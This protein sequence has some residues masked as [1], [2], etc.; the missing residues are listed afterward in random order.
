MSILTLFGKS[1]HG[2]NQTEG[3]PVLS[4]LPNCGPINTT[5][6]KYGAFMEMPS[7]KVGKPG[8]EVTKD[9]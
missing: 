3:T 8:S 7:A 1:I 4:V 5:S 2:F 6:I 9:S